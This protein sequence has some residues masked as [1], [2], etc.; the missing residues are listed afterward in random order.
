MSSFDDH[1]ATSAF[2][3]LVNVLGETYSR[4]PLRVS[5]N[6]EDVAGVWTPSSDKFEENGGDQILIDGVLELYA[7]Q[8]VD[9]ENDSFGIEGNEYQI[10]SI[11]EP[12]GGTKMAKLRRADRTTTSAEGYTRL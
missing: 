12:C 11:S 1:F 6:A 5:G 4:Y 2:P 3:Q 9:E 7:T 8:T 10:V